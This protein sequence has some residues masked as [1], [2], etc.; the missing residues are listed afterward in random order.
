VASTDMQCIDPAGHLLR[1]GVRELQPTGHNCATRPKL[2]PIALLSIAALSA[3]SIVA[4]RTANLPAPIAACAL[5]DPTPG[6]GSEFDSALSDATSAYG[7][8]LAGASPAAAAQ[9][10]RTFAAAAAAYVYGMPQE[11]LLQTIKGYVHNEIVN[12]NALATPTTVGVVSPNVD[13]AYSVAWIDLATGPLVVNVPNTGGRFYT[14]QFLDAY[15]NAF[16]YVGSG[17]TGTAAGAYALVPPGWTGT[18]PPGV[19]EIKSPTNTVWLL[20]RTLVNG[21]SDFPAVKQIQDQYALTPLSAWET[22]ARVPS[23]TL[24][25]YPSSKKPPLPT[26]TAF[27]STL[28]Q[29]LTIDPPPAADDCALAAMAPAGVVLSHPTAAE[30]VA[31]D[32]ANIAGLTP[33]LDENAA[34][35]AA[36]DAGVA[37]GPKIVA[38]ATSKLLVA[39][40]RGNN[41]W[42]VLSRSIGTYGTEYLGRAIIAAD[43]L[44]ANIPAQGIYPVAYVDVAGRTFDGADDYTI[45]FP[46]GLL[47]PA[48]AFWSLTVYDSDNFLYANSLNRYAIGNRTS[49]LVYGRNGSLTL[50]IQHAEPASGAARANW[51]PAPGGAF[52]M[53][54][55]LYQPSA[56]ALN[57]AWKPPPVFGA[58]EVLRPALSRLRVARGRVHYTDTQVALTRFT[59]ANGRHVV[60]RF[61]HRDR[62]GKNTVSLKRLHLRGRYRLLARPIGVPASY[63][64]ARG[65]A[66]SL[67]LIARR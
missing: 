67:K 3:P 34:S 41:G 25:S 27:I 4:A 35:T 49:G 26:G 65:R 1:A 66:V 56:A 31:A 60:A 55:R 52:H 19:T 15:T 61:T 23:V 12:V 58:G 18:L 39:D 64:N 53:I 13:T 6:L 45:T 16:A 47:P 7:A 48:R 10:E 32:V 51:L 59:I 46:R 28:N 20:G 17:S 36:I 24:S 33:P 2:I 5:G 62:A 57:G 40:A 43:Y 8:T 54:L 21:P 9:A 30:E 37:A 44:G 14:F 29:E 22:G 50:Y 38:E 42:D 63:D 11:T